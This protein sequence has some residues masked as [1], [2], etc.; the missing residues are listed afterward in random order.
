MHIL[1]WLHL[2]YPLKGYV[3]HLCA[4]YTK[5]QRAEKMK[6]ACRTDSIG[7]TVDQA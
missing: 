3:F 5:A 2:V 1:T 7:S 6:F 4:A